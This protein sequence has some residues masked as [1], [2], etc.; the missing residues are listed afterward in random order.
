MFKE[1]SESF[2]ERHRRLSLP[3]SL[4]QFVS[5]KQVPTISKNS[6]AIT[7]EFTKDTDGESFES[8]EETS[9]DNDEIEISSYSDCGSTIENISPRLISKS[10]D[11]GFT[12]F[13]CRDLNLAPYGRE[14]IE[15]AKRSMHG[16]A[17]LGA[18]FDEQ[19]PFEGVRLV[20]ITHINAQTASTIEM[21]VRLGAHLRV[22]PCNVFST[23][24]DIVAAL[25]VSNVPIFAWNH[26]TEDDFWWCIDRAL[27]C[28]N[29]SPNIVRI[30]VFFHV[31]YLLENPYFCIFIYKSYWMMAAMRHD[32]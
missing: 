28:E 3:V 22:A 31:V 14:E 5:S 24:N 11:S 21:L 32:L 26:Q 2:R 8:E 6:L 16:L 1:E 17:A 19:R 23:H 25:A 12:D 27:N 18:S 7:E 15:Y 9:D 13:S 10:T 20:M 4:R 30:V 29:W